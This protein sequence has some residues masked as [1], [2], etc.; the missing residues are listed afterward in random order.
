MLK[1]IV[2]VLE[3]M[4]GMKEVILERNPMNI[5]NV[6]KPLHVTVISKYIRAHI[7][8]RNLMKGIIVT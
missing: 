1:S 5:I 4:K 2:K 3:D 6:V 7:L 8:A